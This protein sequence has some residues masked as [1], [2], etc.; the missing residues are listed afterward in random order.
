MKPSMIK[1]L[2]A[3]AADAVKRKPRPKHRPKKAK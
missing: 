1:M 3:I 2:A